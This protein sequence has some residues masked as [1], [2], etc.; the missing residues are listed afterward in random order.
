MHLGKFFLAFVVITFG[1]F[2]AMDVLNAAD[3]AVDP[4]E[5]LLKEAKIGTDDSSLLAY[6]RK[7][8]SSDSDLKQMDQLIARLG[9]P[10]SKDRE[11]ASQKLIDLGLVALP[12]LRQAAKA[13]DPDFAGRVK[14]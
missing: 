14:A 7:R 3:Q 9:N 2:F 8:S 5:S 1:P 10:N 4:D 6:L 12:F 11:E 13:P